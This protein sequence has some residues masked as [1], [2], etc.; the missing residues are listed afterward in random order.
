MPHI[1]EKQSDQIIKAKGEHR[2]W[3]QV[4][5]KEIDIYPAPSLDYSWQ[6]IDSEVRSTCR[7]FFSAYSILKFKFEH[8]EF[9][10]SV[11]KFGF[12]S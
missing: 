4:H 12:N 6:I 11:T 7:D 2:F 5:K 10:L 3:E 8:E 9:L 1:P